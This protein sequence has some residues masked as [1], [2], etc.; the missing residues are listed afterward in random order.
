M[1][2][3]RLFT[4]TYTRFLFLMLLLLSMSMEAQSFLIGFSD[5]GTAP[6]YNPRNVTV[7]NGSSLLKVKL[8]VATASTN[9]ATVTIQLPNGIEYV[10]GSVAVLSTNASLTITENGG[11]A[12]APQFKLG[13]NTLAVGNDIEFTI[14][15][16]ATCTARTEVLAGTIFKDKVIATIAGT[17]TT[18]DSNSYSVLYPVFSLTQPATQTNAVVG[19]SYNRSFTITN[20]GNGSA[21]AVYFYIEY[22]DNAVVANSITL[23]GGSGSTGAPLVLTPTSVVPSTTPAKTTAYYTIPAAN[24]SDGSFDFGEVLNITENYTVKKCNA[25]TN[26]YTGWGPSSTPANWCDTKSGSASI[27]MQA[28]VP[29]VGVTSTSAAIGTSAACNGRQLSF[30]Y[31]NT[32]TGST[33]SGAMYNIVAILGTVPIGPTIGENGFSVTDVKLNGIPLNLGGYTVGS[34]NAANIDMSQFTSDPDGAGVGLEDLDGDGLYND[35][36]PG[37]SFTITYVRKLIPST[38][39]PTYYYGTPATKV[40]YQTM[41]KETTPL[42]SNNVLGQ[43]IDAGNFGTNGVSQLAPP[44]IYPNTPFDV[45]IGVSGS[46]NPLRPYGTDKV[47]LKITLPPGVTFTGLANT[48]FNGTAPIQ[49]VSQVGN[50]LTLSNTWFDNGANPTAA[51]GFFMNAQFTYDCSGSGPVV[52]TY[53]VYYAEDE[54][55][56]VFSKMACGNTFSLATHC[57]SPCPPGVSNKAANVKRLNYGFTDKTLSTPVDPTTLPALTRKTAAVY[58]QVNINQAGT[59]VSSFNNLY[60]YFQEDKANGFDIFNYQGGGTLH[61]KAGGTGPEIVV[62]LPAP[63]NESTSLLTKLRFNLTPLLGTGGLPS[64][65]NDGDQYWV[66]MNFVIGSA[67]NP[68]LFGL[69]AQAPK[70]SEA[71]FYNLDS[72]NTEKFCDKAFPEIYLIGIRD[73][74]AGDYAHQ[75]TM[76]GCQSIDYS[77]QDYRSYTTDNVNPFVGEFRPTQYIDKIE[78][79]LPAGYALDPNVQPRLQTQYFTNNSAL[80]VSFSNVNITPVVNGNVVT[81]TNPGNWPASSIMYATQFSN[82]L[83]QYAILGTCAVDANASTTI[84]AKYYVRDYYYSNP[85]SSNPIVTSTI[86]RNN[87]I[88]VNTATIP[89]IQLTNQSG[90]IQASKP[91]ESVTFRISSTGTATAPYNWFSIPTVNGV[92]ITKVVDVATGTTLTPIA[93]SGGVWYK[94]NDAGLA[95]GAF[96]DYRVEFNYSVCTQTA[97]HIEAGWNCPGYP[98]SPDT[99]PCTKSTV[100]ISFIPQPGEV[101]IVTVKQPSNPITGLCNPLDYAFQ[102]NSAGAGNLTDVKFDINLITGTVITPGSILA[103]YPAGAGNWAAVSTTTNGNVIKLDLTTHPA[104]PAQGLPGTL[105]DGGNANNRLIGVR[106]KITTDCTFVSGSNFTVTPHAK[107]TCGSV[108]QGSGSAVAANSINIAGADPAYLVSSKITMSPLAFNGCATPLNI[109]IEQTITATNPTGT[110]GTVRIDLPIGYDFVGTIACSTTYCP[111]VL[112]VNTD[113]TN[114]NRYMILSIPA[115][116]IS[117]DKMN[118]TVAVTK[119]GF[120]ACDTTNSILVRGFDKAGNISCPSAPGGVCSNVTIQTGT[121][122]FDFTVT[123][124]SYSIPSLTGSITG[125]NFVGSISVKNTSTIDSSST[126]PIVVKFYCADAAGNQAAYLGTY[127][128]TGTIAAGATVNQPF[129]IT[130]GNICSTSRIVAAIEVPEN[131]ACSTATGTFYLSCFKPGNVVAGSTI[132]TK[133]GITS[134]GRAGA[135][136]GNWPMVR[137]SAWTVLESQTKGF[138]VNRLTDTQMAAIPAAD[139]KEGMMIYN[140]TQ[141]CLMINIDGTAGGWKCYKNPACP[142]Q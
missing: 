113:A 128:L 97:I 40:L 83:L 69:T 88:N 123:N 80:G 119:T 55:C 111:T 107:N 72:S 100:D 11:T 57:P 27:S 14:A 116:M 51:A 94:A 103:E 37:Q 67:K 122:S 6:T 104:Y 127:T 106:F 1:K 70:N 115:G 131:C 36:A 31:T 23:T 84:S 19:N 4:K 124:P 89:K 92:T 130:I 33:K 82:A 10:P 102:V 120:V 87:P 32:G 3:K 110:T 90:T 71:Y 133:H 117:G 44:S 48:S 108:T 54:T 13:P 29:N 112:S 99:Y 28:G 91:T 140:I 46:Y 95:S 42:S 7:S 53:D 39:C 62:N 5:F 65:L 60:Y 85:T 35:L 132:P 76:T 56:G 66:D 24:L 125:N 15:R 2:I 74:G 96:K 98:T 16:R 20:G 79:T 50:V 63:A 18:A 126:N 38:V 142:D 81:F 8:S 141:Q 22:M 139:L 121:Y 114:N 26:Y 34:G 43:G 41:C 138:V 47:Y 17:P 21:N 77:L 135:A 101:Q 59:Q 30:T 45:R 61:F 93:Y 64:V 137:N 105:N 9:G 25:L 109:P 52:F 68:E 73:T 58:D 12:Q 49:G 86:V 134:L 136:N 75:R 118:Y 78:V 129:N